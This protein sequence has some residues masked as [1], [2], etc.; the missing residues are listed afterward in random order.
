MTTLRHTYVDGVYHYDAVE[1]PPEEQSEYGLD[2]LEA[3]GGKTYLA[4]DLYRCST[5]ETPHLS[6]SELD[7]VGECVECATDSEQARRDEA[8]KWADYRAWSL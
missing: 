8:E 2:E 5:C 6:R 3:L 7:D 1:V 4:D